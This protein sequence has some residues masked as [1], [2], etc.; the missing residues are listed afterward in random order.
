VSP[1]K[2]ILAGVLVA[3]VLPPLPTE[4]TWPVVDTDVATVDAVVYCHEKD[5]SAIPSGVMAGLNRLNRDRNVTATV[6]ED[7]TTTG[8][9]DVPE[10]Y[11]LPLEAARKHGMP[12]LVVMAGGKVLRVVKVATSDDVWGAVP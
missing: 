1:W 8:D 10:Q 5:D 9:G 7:D 6:F 12:C 4:W 3:V 11:R 2:F